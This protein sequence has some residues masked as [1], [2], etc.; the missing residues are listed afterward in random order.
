MQCSQKKLRK[1]RLT[2][3]T[4][5]WFKDAQGQ[6]KKT[7]GKNKPRSQQNGVELKYAQEMLLE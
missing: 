3:N 5:L 4:T 1:N 2:H 6:T 7:Q